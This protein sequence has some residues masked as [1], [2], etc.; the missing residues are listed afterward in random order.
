MISREDIAR[1]SHEDFETALRER[2]VA[3][4]AKLV[5]V[6]SDLRELDQFYYAIALDRTHKDDDNIPDDMGVMCD[7]LREDINAYT[8]HERE[9]FA[10]RNS[11]RQ[12]IIAILIARESAKRAVKRAEH[13]PDDFRDILN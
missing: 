9:M 1:F 3:L 12:M 11:Y 8:P 6:T 4:S 13:L 7:K 10:L 2:I 5:S